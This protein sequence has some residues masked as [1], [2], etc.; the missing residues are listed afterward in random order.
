[1]QQTQHP[2]IL[3]RNKLNIPSS[4]DYPDVAMQTYAQLADPHRNDDA[5]P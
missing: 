2:M 5:S 1:M 3:K 4:V